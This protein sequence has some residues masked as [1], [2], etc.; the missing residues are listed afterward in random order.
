MGDLDD[1]KKLSPEDRVE[2]LK[3]IEEKNKKEIEEAQKLMTE[4]MRELESVE[5]M[6]RDIPIPQLTSVD[7]D[8]LFGTEEKEMFKTKRFESSDK[9]VIEKEQGE[10]LEE[11]LAKEKTPDLPDDIVKQYTQQLQDMS[12]RLSEFKNMDEAHF[13]KYQNQYE[14]ELG[15]MY[16]NAKKAEQYASMHEQVESMHISDQIGDMIGGYKRG[17]V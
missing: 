15:V 6:K 14:E 12:N 13:Q 9:K 16:D 8:T 3:E 1:L 2:K 17:G 4:S 10:T 5:E 7:V 11:S